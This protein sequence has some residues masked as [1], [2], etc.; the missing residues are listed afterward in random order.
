M[1]FHKMILD[2]ISY[3]ILKMDATLKA[4]DICFLFLLLIKSAN[5][6]FYLSRLFTKYK[7]WFWLSYISLFIV[8]SSS[9]TFSFVHSTV[10][11]CH[12]YWSIS[13]KIKKNNNS[14]N[15]NGIHCVTWRTFIWN[16]CNDSSLFIKNQDN[17]L[18]VISMI[19]LKHRI[20][21][22]MRKAF[23]LILL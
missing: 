21:Y 2:E 19:I 6:F 15:M 10:F 8:Q 13:R 16:Y 1:K 12:R 11:F 17:K 22:L 9:I 14:L 4:L 23:L 18:K 5:I 20:I 7:R 3:C